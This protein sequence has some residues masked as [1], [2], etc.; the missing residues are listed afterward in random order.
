MFQRLEKAASLNQLLLYW[1]EIFIAYLLFYFYHAL[2][3]IL[4]DKIW[5]QTFTVRIK[6][7]KYL[8]TPLSC[9]YFKMFGFGLKKEDISW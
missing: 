5:M 8:F 7:L 2:S 4:G 1:L 3:R 9:E 6:Y